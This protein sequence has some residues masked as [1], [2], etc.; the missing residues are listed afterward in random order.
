[1][2][3][4]GPKQRGVLWKIK[5]DYRV[6]KIMD[7]FLDEFH[8]RREQEI[9]DFNRQWGN[10]LYKVEKVAGELTPRWKAHLYMKKLRLDATK[11]SQ[12]LT[13]ALGVYTVDALSKSAL[14]TFPSIR[15]IATKSCSSW[16][17]LCY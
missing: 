4:W 13:G 10:E 8:R 12:I 5:E 17:N 1:M 6:G 7:E 2:R 3:H 15:E 14:T 11:K 9:I 16:W